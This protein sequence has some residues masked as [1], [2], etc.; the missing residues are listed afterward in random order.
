[1]TTVNVYKS[2]KVLAQGYL[3]PF[4][5]RFHILKSLVERE[6][7][8]PT[9]LQDHAGDTDP[10]TSIPTEEEHHE[11]TEPILTP[12][13]QTSITELK[14]HF[15]Q[16]EME[17]VHLR[18]MVLNQTDKN[19]AQLW[20]QQQMEQMRIEQENLQTTHQKQLLK[21]RESHKKDLFTPTEQV[22]ELQKEEDQNRWKS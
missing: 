7:T 3:K 16:L 17:L 22:R 10:P 12:P 1:M 4:Q 15:T 5:V 11:D 9:Q 2:G 14:E 19:S 18:E 6:N 20:Q 13:H 21:D 8:S